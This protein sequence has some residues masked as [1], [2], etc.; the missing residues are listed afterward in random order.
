[1]MEQEAG[2][3]QVMTS[4]IWSACLHVLACRTI[5]LRVDSAITQYGAT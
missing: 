4:V 2:L 5:H 1:M 3:E